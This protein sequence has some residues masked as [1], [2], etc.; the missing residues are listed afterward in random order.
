[1][2]EADKTISGETDCL[3]PDT[4]EPADPRETGRQVR[5]GKDPFGT[6]RREV[7]QRLREEMEEHLA[8]PTTRIADIE[9]VEIVFKDGV[10]PRSFPQSVGFKAAILGPGGLPLLPALPLCQSLE[11]TGSVLCSFRIVASNELL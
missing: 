1:M 9:N 11:R 3:S 2:T 5:P 10:G 6:K 8:L 7:D 4:P